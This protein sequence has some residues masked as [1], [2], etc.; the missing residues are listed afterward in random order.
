MEPNTASTLAPLYYSR[1]DQDY[2][3]IKLALVQIVG[4]A[5]TNS[6]RHKFARWPQ[7]ATRLKAESNNMSTTG[8]EA[9]SEKPYLKI[10]IF[11]RAEEILLAGGSKYGEMMENYRALEI[12]ILEAK[13]TRNNRAV[14][15]KQGMKSRFFKFSSACVILFHLELKDD[16]FQS[17]KHVCH[18]SK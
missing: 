17:I 12:T 1:E 14:T 7:K 5:G 11:V 18:S 3:L 4:I 6:T 2:Y 13:H 15:K 9:K 16:V 10:L 8:L